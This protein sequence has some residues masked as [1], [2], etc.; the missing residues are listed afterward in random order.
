[1]LRASGKAARVMEGRTRLCQSPRPEMGSQRSV[2]PKNSMSRM[3]S[4]KLGSDCP[5][6]PQQG[7]EV[8]EDGVG[9]RS[10]EDTQRNGKDDRDEKGQHRQFKRRREAIHHDLES[11]LVVLERLAEIAANCF[12]GEIGILH[13]PGAVKAPG[14]SKFIDLRLGHEIGSASQH[15]DSRVAGEVRQPERDDAH[16]EDDDDG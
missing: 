3:P 16:A 2:T 6:E 5:I 15:D 12:R 13:I 4:Q 11:G 9:T 1:M 8:I 7:T 10:G 14:M